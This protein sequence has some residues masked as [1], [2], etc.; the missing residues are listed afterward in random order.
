MLANLTLGVTHLARGDEGIFRL[1]TRQDFGGRLIS[2]FLWNPVSDDYGCEP[3][4]TLRPI[5]MNYYLMLSTVGLPV[6]TLAYF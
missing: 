2:K 5:S 4:Q 1:K 6:Y 3:S